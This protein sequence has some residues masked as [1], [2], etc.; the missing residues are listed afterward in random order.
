MSTRDSVARKAPCAD[1]PAIWQVGSRRSGDGRSSRTRFIGRPIARKRGSQ[2]WGGRASTSSLDASHLRPRGHRY[3]WSAPRESPPATTAWTSYGTDCGPPND[4]SDADARSLAPPPP[5]EVALAPRYGMR[6]DLLSLTSPRHSHFRLE[7]GHHSSLW[8][9]L[10]GLFVQP[11]AIH[12]FV[13][14]LSRAL[15]PHKVA[16]VCGPLVG[17]AFLAQMLA[18]ALK[19]EFFFTERWLPEAARATSASP[20]S[21]TRSAPVPRSE[22]RTPSCRGTA[23]NPSSSERSWYWA[24]QRRR[25]SRNGVCRLKPY[26]A[27]RSTCGCRPNVR[28]AP[29][30]RHSRILDCARESPHL[31]RHPKEAS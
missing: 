27:S 16:G 3:F 29:P 5:W 6:R 30:G 17:G 7:S 31:K 18:A 10:E 28:C 8:L 4:R 11:A 12:P 9:D 14:R 2:L 26:R 19:V 21:T 15:R 24:A 20:S 1:S 13:T 25:T 22:P 23:P